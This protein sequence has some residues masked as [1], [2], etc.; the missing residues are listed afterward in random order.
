MPTKNI[1]TTDTGIT[2]PVSQKIPTANSV[3]AMAEQPSHTEHDTPQTSTD[4]LGNRAI[5]VLVSGVSYAGEI[6]VPPEPRQIPSK[7]FLNFPA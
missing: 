6:P 4:W 5:G 7:N 3:D 2:E 1:E